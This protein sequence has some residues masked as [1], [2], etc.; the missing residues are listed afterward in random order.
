MTNKSTN[1][2]DKGK[3][4]VCS[5]T[6]AGV[7]FPS[8]QISTWRPTNISERI[9]FSE[10]LHS[11]LSCVTP[12]QTWFFCQHSTNLWQEIATF[13]ILCAAIWNWIWSLS[14]VLVPH[15]AK[16]GTDILCVASPLRSRGCLRNS[17]LIFETAVWFKGLSEMSFVILE[18]ALPLG[19]VHYVIT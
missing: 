8:S 5:W 19:A 1:I 18:S 15:K 4:C 14:N 3:T 7:C 2:N 9:R 6:C 11:C 12:Q 13:H 10:K 16:C 17:P